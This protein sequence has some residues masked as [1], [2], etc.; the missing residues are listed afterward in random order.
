M[1]KPKAS[2]L[3]TVKHFPVAQKMEI[4]QLADQKVKKSLYFKEN[5]MKQCITYLF[6]DAV[7]TGPLVKVKD[8]KTKGKKFAEKR[9]LTK[10]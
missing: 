4:F 10:E 5:V 7:L 3:V 8:G 6:K 2:N 1:G 9:N